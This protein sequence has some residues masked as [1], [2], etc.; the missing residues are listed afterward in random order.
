MSCQSTD[1]TLFQ[2]GIQA[3]D[4]VIVLQTKEHETF[5]RQGDDLFMKKTISLTE[6]LCGYSFVVKHLDGRNILIQGKPGDVIEPGKSSGFPYAIY[7]L[8]WAILIT[9]WFLILFSILK[10]IDYDSAV[11]IK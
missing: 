5:T 8:F 9:K 3:G 4:V 10:S 6:A 11:V 2:P 1:S 7:A